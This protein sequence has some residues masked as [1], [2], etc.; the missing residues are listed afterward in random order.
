MFKKS[1]FTLIALFIFCNATFFNAYASE[2]SFREVFIKM[3]YDGIMDKK[4][5][6]ELKRISY[7]DSNNKLA[8]ETL[9]NI[10]K[11]KDRTKLIYSLQ[12]YNSRNFTKLE[13]TITPTYSE[14]ELIP[15]NTPLEKISQI[16]QKD[17]MSNTN[18]DEDRC[19]IASLINAYLYMNGDFTKLANKFNL[20]S[21]LTYKNIHLLQDI[22]Y[23][24]S[25]TDNEAGIYSGYKYYS[26]YQ[27][28]HISKIIP[29]GEIV[30][31]ANLV[32]I[33]LL[34]LVG[35]N[36]NTLSYKKNAV[37]KFFSNYPQ[38]A[39]IVGVKLNVETGLISRPES[40]EAQDHFITVFKHKNS[41]YL[42]DTSAIN[43][44]DGKNVRKMTKSELNNLV[45]N[46]DG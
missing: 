2:E 21:S 37:E 11:F 14:E 19:G 4:E 22:I 8:E 3:A 27:T 25:N 6:N 1:S 9:K 12:D 32:G 17:N 16:S 43:N 13:F 5:I 40:V 35:N 46:T 23:K 36:I 30:T 39:L 10:L 7:N 45:L 42:S 44:G 28:G 24:K 18:S 41:F 29:S 20:S 31:A 15:G 38:G 34:P 33:E 26:S